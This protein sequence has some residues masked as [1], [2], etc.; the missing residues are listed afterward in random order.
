MSNSIAYLSGAKEENYEE[1]AT[2]GEKIS[3][4]VVK[5]RILHEKSSNSSRDKYNNTT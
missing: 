2:V 5:Y 3:I 4:I 1:G